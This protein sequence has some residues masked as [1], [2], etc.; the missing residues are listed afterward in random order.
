MA[1]GKVSMF[2]SW[3]KSSLQSALKHCRTPLIFALSILIPTASAYAQVTRPDTMITV[4]LC[5]VLSLAS[6]SFGAALTIV[7]G[8]VALVGSA[9]GS[10]KAAMSVL[11]VAAGTWLIQPLMELFFGIAICSGGQSMFV[12][13]MPIGGMN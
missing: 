13:N 10:Y 1:Q 5:N 6:G 12:P 4:G 8:L 7:A 9:M 3:Q 2:K 11:I